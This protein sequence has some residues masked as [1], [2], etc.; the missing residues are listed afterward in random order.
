MPER[1][2]DF[3]D[4]NDL[5]EIEN[6]PED[7]QEKFIQEYLQTLELIAQRVGGILKMKVKVGMPGGG[8]FFDPESVSITF[9]PLHLIEDIEEAKFVAGHEGAHRAITPNPKE[10]GL[11]TEKTR[12][13][14]SQLGFP[15][16]QNVIEDGAI[17][18]WLMKR[19]PG[20]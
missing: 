4:I 2:R 19:F 12:E 6:L 14:Y 7:E 16:M 9:D 20:L 13:L 5:S 11:S 17:N 3:S 10:I 15:Y 8:S 18:S 1:G